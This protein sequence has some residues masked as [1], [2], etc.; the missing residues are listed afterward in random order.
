MDDVSV[1]ATHTRYLLEP[2][3][4][5]CCCLGL[6]LTVRPTPT[7]GQ[8]GVILCRLIYALVMITKEF[9]KIHW[10]MAVSAIASLVHQ[11]CDIAAMVASQKMHQTPALTA[12]S[13]RTA[14]RQCELFSINKARFLGEGISLA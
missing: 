12:H 11:E 8:G 7:P 2:G 5:N 4:A 6:V 3:Q 14:M 10:A 9:E 13:V 1:L